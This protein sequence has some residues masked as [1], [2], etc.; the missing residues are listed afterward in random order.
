MHMP[1]AHFELLVRYPKTLP[2]DDLREFV[3][4]VAREHISLKVDRE[5]GGAQAGVE[6]LLPTTVAVI[7]AFASKAY[8]DGFMKEA[9][10][11]HYQ[12]LKK[13]IGRLG[14][15]FTK[16]P[17][18]LAASGSKKLAP[19]DRYS[20]VFSLMVRGQSGLIKLLVPN[21]ASQEELETAAFAFLKLI[22]ALDSDQPPK[23][24]VHGGVAIVTYDATT[25]KLRPVDLDEI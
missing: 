13:A 12:A 25:G 6:W 4:V 15:R 21:R 1:S 24:R 2:D 8:L 17:T 20:P 18:I 16:A 5:G 3:D 9:G 19:H 11:D 10:K 22:E 14:T 7:F 23:L